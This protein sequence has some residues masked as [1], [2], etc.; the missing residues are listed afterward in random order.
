VL[1]NRKTN[2]VLFVV[3]FALIPINKEAEDALDE[4]LAGGDNEKKDDETQD[5][6]LD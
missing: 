5:D 2:Q 1:K 4:K 6:D 3:N